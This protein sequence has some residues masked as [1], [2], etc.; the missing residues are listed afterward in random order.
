MDQQL[1]A[2]VV[3]V[4]VEQAVTGDWEECLTWRAH[5]RPALE[6]EDLWR[7]E[8]DGHLLYRTDSMHLVEEASSEVVAL[9]GRLRELLLL[10]SCCWVQVHQGEDP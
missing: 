4:V 6:E 1:L 10:R 7:Q 9:A 8:V 5:P 3:M 2:G